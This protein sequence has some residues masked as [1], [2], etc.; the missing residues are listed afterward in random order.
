[1]IALY[2][3]SDGAFIKSYPCLFLFISLVLTVAI[4]FLYRGWVRAISTNH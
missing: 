1:M 4:A 2:E 3:I